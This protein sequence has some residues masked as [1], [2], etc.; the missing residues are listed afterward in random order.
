M[1]AIGYDIHV[2]V[3]ENERA[4]GHPRGCCAA[5]GSKLLGTW[6]K[7]AMAHH[8]IKA[9]N[10]VN[11]AGCLDYCE[12]GPVVVI[13]GS[14]APGGVWYAPTSR[15]DVDEIVSRHL[16]GGEPVARLRLE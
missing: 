13:Y 10:R 6:F 12:R 2:F 11:R 5:R 14:A 7:E 1:S 4:K 15:E 8:G 3:C 16:V 9:G